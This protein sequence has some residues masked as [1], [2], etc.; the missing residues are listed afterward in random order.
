MEIEDIPPTTLKPAPVIVACEIV[1]EAVPVLVR[2][3]AWVLLEP[4]FTFPKDRLVALA[5]SD[6]DEAVLEV[7]FAA[8][9]PAPVNPVHPEMDRMP[10][11]TRK[12]VSRLN[13][14]IG[15]ETKSRR[16]LA[17]G[18]DFMANTV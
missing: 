1:T 3:R 15:F 14:L 9:V 4:V 12:V 13:G 5:A 18:C 6:P 17:F 8:G 16:G 7:L 2:V 11:R 10:K